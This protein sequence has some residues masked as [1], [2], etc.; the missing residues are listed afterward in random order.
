MVQEVR[1]VASSA[2]KVAFQVRA[3]RND[4]GTGHGRATITDID[5][6]LATVAVDAGYLWCRWALKRLGHALADEP[7][8]LIETLQTETFTKKVLRRQLA[9]IRMPC[10]PAEV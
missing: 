8:W 2:R 5:D 7:Q 9:A 3:I 6:E 1:T 4:H 10:Q